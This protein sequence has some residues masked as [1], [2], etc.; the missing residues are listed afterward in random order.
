MTPGPTPP[1]ALVDRGL[2]ALGRTVAVDGVQVS[3]VV[4]RVKFYDSYKGVNIPYVE[5]SSVAIQLF[6]VGTGGNI[7]LG[8]VVTVA[9]YE[10]F[11][12]DLGYAVAE[13]LSD[14]YSDV[15][16]DGYSLDVALSGSVLY[17]F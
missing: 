15:D 12:E 9:D 17:V 4:F 1:P 16:Q 14:F 7:V 6:S 3:T 11:L 2:Y 8:Q 13:V 5:Q 10:L